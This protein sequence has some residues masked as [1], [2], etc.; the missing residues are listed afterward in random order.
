MVVGRPGTLLG[1]PELPLRL[2]PANHKV[3][4]MSPERKEESLWEPAEEV[5]GDSTSSEG[6]RITDSTDDEETSSTESAQV[7][8]SALNSRD[9]RVNV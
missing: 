3:K 8:S 9:F 4:A 2:E 6:G 7:S 1:Q 5:E